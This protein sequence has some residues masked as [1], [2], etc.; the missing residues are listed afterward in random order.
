MRKWS[1]FLLG[2]LIMLVSMIGAGAEEE[3]SMFFLDQLAL[4]KKPDCITVYMGDRYAMEIPADWTDAHDSLTQMEQLLFL[5]RGVDTN[6]HAALVGAFALEDDPEKVSTFFE[7]FENEMPIRFE[8]TLYGAKWNGLG[9]ES[10]AMMLSESGSDGRRYLVLFITE[11]EK[12]PLSG[13]YLRLLRTMENSIRPQ[14]D[15]EQEYRA[16]MA[17]LQGKDLSPEE[18]PVSFHDPE[19]E[20]MVR[21]TMQ[22]KKD[23]I[24]PSEL[25]AVRLIAICSGKISFLNTLLDIDRDYSQ[26]APLS[27]R[28]LALFPNLRT[29]YTCDMQTSDEE[30]L[31]ELRSLKS[32]TMIRAGLTDCSLF[33]QMEQLEDLSISGN[34]VYDLSPLGEL[35]ELRFLNV[36]SCGVRSMEAVAGLT[37]LEDLTCS[38][39]PIIDLSPLAELTHLQTLRIADTDILSLEPLRNLE[40]LESLDLSQIE[41]TLSLEPL[42]AL[43]ALSDIRISGTAIDEESQDFYGPY[44]QGWSIRIPVR[45]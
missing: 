22:R 10:N 32:L 40:S 37:A 8:T 15:G 7:S 41:G 34:E 43:P 17:K 29:V 39:N 11:S 28:D 21:E 13:E 42:F 14:H 5:Y 12:E 24:Y 1:A 20:R 44:T 36:S 18:A 31:F 27:L 26:P 23:P 19:F 6:G 4:D 30:T 16:E 38:S 3:Y 25:A 9:D 35:T 2:V 45:K 33:S